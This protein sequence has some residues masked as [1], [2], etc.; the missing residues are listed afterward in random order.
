MSKRIPFS[1]SENQE[2]KMKIA[3]FKALLKNRMKRDDL[4]C[5]EEFW[6]SKATQCD[7]NI[8]AMWPNKYLNS[9]YHREQI[10]LLTKHLPDNIS[11]T[12]ILDVGCGTGRISRYLAERGATIVGTDFSAHAIAIAK[13]QSPGS[14]PSY[15]VQ[16]IFELDEEENFDIVVVVGVLAVACRD[17]TDLLNALSRV[18][19]A[20]KPDGKIFLLEP[21]HSG[22]LHRVLNMRFDKFLKVMSE[23]GLGVDE[24]THCQFWPMR[25]ALAYLPWP[26][27][28]TSA[29]YHLGKWTMAL[30][31]NRFLGD[32]KI[33]LAS[34]Q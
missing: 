13:I 11:G 18:R 29:G 24:I 7:G 1:S 14:N 33:I 27:F 9:Y 23:A 19:N 10:A 26:K 28:I 5:T 4:Y 25:L 34:R 22:F 31:G 20:V 16:S 15:K 6:D 2:V 3:G 8:Y 12:R 30:L 17:R 21:I 32:Y